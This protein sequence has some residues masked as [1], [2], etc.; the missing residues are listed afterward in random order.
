M[1]QVD[2]ICVA[3]QATRGEVPTPGGVI[4]QD[5]LWRLEHAF[6]PIPMVGWLILK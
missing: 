5:R 4:Y 6:E 3:C 1:G 2:P